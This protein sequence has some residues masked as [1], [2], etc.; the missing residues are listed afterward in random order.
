MSLPQRLWPGTLVRLLYVVAVVL[1][2]PLQ[3]YPVTV[4][5]LSFVNGMVGGEGG[6]AVGAGGKEEGQ[7]DVVSARVSGG[8]DHTGGD[9]D[10]DGVENGNGGGDGGDDG[11][12]DGGRLERGSRMSDVLLSGTDSQDSHLEA[13]TDSGAKPTTPAQAETS[14]SAAVPMPLWE[15]VAR[16]SLVACLAL[17][18]IAGQHSLDH[19]VSLLGSL[20]SAPLALIVP[21]VGARVWLAR[22]C[23]TPPCHAC[24]RPSMP[25]MCM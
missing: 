21:P 24:V 15:V 1:T 16:T 25:C 6:G 22:C 11:G 5:M 12:G 3:L 2:F 9:G 17:L 13:A 18:A 4:T 20:S 23:L 10:G 19:I 14:G 8:G 7:E